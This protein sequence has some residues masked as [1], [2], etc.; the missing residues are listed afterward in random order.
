MIGRRSSTRKF[1]SIALRGTNF[2][3][4]CFVVLMSC[5]P[6]SPTPK[7]CSRFI[8]FFQSSTV[9]IQVEAIPTKKARVRTP[10]FSLVKKAAFLESEIER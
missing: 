2:F 6:A 7:P 3:G 5:L 9:S 4:F 10:D 1:L 8:A